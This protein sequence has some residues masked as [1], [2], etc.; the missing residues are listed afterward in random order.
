[1]KLL[2]DE[3]IDR[4]VVEKLRSRNID[5]AYVEEEIKGA[6]DTEVMEKAVSERRVLVTF[7]S[8]FLEPGA[9]HPGII[10]VTRPDRYEIIVEL[11]ENLLETFSP[12]DFHNTVVEVSPSEF[13]DR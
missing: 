11:V 12:Q 8:D 10:R 1:M 7:D 2:A 3:N 4:A 6:D 5:T 13:K 9:E